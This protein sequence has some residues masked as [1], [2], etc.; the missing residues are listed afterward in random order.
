M[1]LNSATIQLRALNNET[2][3]PEGYSAI[4]ICWFFDEC[5]EDDNKYVFNLQRLHVW[6][7]KNADELAERQLSELDQFILIMTIGESNREELE[8]R[9]QG[10]TVRYPTLSSNKDRYGVVGLDI[11]H[12]VPRSMKGSDALRNMYPLPPGLH[13]L[14]HYYGSRVFA[15]PET[16]AAFSFMNSEMEIIQ[17]LIDDGQLKSGWVSCPSPTLPAVAKLCYTILNLN[18][19]LTEVFLNA[20]VLS[21]PITVIAVVQYNKMKHDGGL[22]VNYDVNTQFV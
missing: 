19:T 12:G 7:A 2:R 9:L 17:G 20:L 10:R 4:D 14:V 6:R 21:M 15:N 11:H 1:R 5:D 16:V 18:G 22:L 3:R 13:V 8:R